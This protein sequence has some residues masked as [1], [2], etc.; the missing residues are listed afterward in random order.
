[1]D[2]GEGFNYNV[3]IAGSAAAPAINMGAKILALPPPVRTQLLN[4]AQT[5]APDQFG[6]AYQALIRLRL[7]EINDN[8][9]PTNTGKTAPVGFLP[10]AAVDYLENTGVTP[11]TAIILAQDKRITRMVRDLKKEKNIAVD[12]DFILNILQH[13][14]NPNRVLYDT[15]N[16]NLLFVI[17]L[18]N[19]AANKLVV[20]TN[21]TAR[22]DRQNL[23]ANYIWSASLISSQELG[24][25]EEIK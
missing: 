18:P 24:K 7:S 2:H 22:V 3:G 8:Q 9:A 23:Q 13:I 20:Q 16:K 4:H 12:D 5:L 25:F 1:M 11:N 6:G 14:A 19:N 21:Q 17:D 15:N 10:A